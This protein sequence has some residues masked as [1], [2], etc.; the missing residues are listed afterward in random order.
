MFKNAQAKEKLGF[1]G[2][3]CMLSKKKKKKKG[4]WS[5]TI[6]LNPLF[7]TQQT[8]VAMNIYRVTRVL[9]SVEIG[10]HFAK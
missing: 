8:V 6:A 3:I 7:T 2:S 10:S 9:R 5:L 1:N 4:V